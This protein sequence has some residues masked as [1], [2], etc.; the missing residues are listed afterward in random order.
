MLNNLIMLLMAP[1]CLQWR[2]E[3]YLTEFILSNVRGTYISY[4]SDG[5]GMNGA[6]VDNTFYLGIQL[7]HLLYLLYGYLYC[8]TICSLI[9]NFQHFILSVYYCLFL[10]S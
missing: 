6:N 7:L 3:Q 4:N 1:N 10:K 2:N 8:L 9:V 5:T